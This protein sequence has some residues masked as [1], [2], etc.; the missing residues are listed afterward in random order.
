MAS[1]FQDQDQNQKQQHLE[2]LGWKPFFANQVNNGETRVPVRITAVHSHGFQILG[3]YIDTMIQPV[4]GATVGDWLLVHPIHTN[5][6]INNNNTNINI[7]NINNINNN[8]IIPLERNNILQRR[9]PGS[10]RTIQLMAA[11]LD[12]LFVVSSCNQEF[13]VARLERYIALALEANITPVIIL[14]KPDL[15]D[16]PTTKAYRMAAA[17]T[18]PNIPVILVDARGKQPTVQ[19]AP[20]CQ[21]GQTVAFVG[22]SGVGKSTLVNALCGSIMAE[23]SPIRDD[24]SKGR[25]TTSHRQLHFS[26]YGCAIL[27]T[28][29]MR[30]LQLMDA[31]SG[32]ADLFADIVELATQCRFSNCQ[33]AS[34]P[35]CAIQTSIHNGDLDPI[36]FARWQKLAAE[37]QDNSKRMAERKPHPT[38]RATKIRKQQNNEKKNRSFK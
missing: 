11:N 28:P 26:K 2:Q 20:W 35:S 25:H 5:N 37:D 9:A 32:V 19:L 29:G 15:V 36:R 6:N 17:A 30:E 27:D 16:E 13:N 33:H 38:N 18:Y 34:E 7:N 31:A 10:G 1:I 22:S 4:A 12:T 14:T 23:T 24:D 3:E 21:P 8:N